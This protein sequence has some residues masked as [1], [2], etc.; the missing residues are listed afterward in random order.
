MKIHDIYQLQ[1]LKFYYK[2]KNKSLPKYFDTFDLR[3]NQDMHAHFTRG[4]QN[5]RTVTVKH[6]FSQK[7]LRYKLPQTINAT[8]PII[9]QKVFSHSLKGFGNYYKR[10]CILNYADVCQIQNCYIC[11]HVVN[12]YIF[13]LTAYPT[14]FF[15]YF[16]LYNV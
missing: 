7:C 8:P 11:N 13:L 4:C 12:W 2:Y 9:T 14:I 3:L 10:N 6:T 15:L 1:Q 5:L 16:S